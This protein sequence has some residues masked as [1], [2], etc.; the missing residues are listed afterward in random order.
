MCGII[1]VPFDTVDTLWLM[2]SCFQTYLNL[3]PLMNVMA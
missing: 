2:R 3:G 1:D